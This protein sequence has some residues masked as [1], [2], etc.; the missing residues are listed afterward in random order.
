M[1][2]MQENPFRK[3]FSDLRDLQELRCRAAE[4]DLRIDRK[5]R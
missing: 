5:Y 3:F 2:R 1:N 4:E